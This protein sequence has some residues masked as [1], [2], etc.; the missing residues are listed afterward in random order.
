MRVRDEPLSI[1]DRRPYARIGYEDGP[2]VTV[3]IPGLD[4]APG[5]RTRYNAALLHLRASLVEAQAYM[6]APLPREDWP[7]EPADLIKRA[8]ELVDSWTAE[9]ATEAAD[10]LAEAQT[11]VAVAMG[12]LLMRVWADPVHELET[13]TAWEA[14]R[15]A[16]EVYRSPSHADPSQA[17]GL[18]SYDE[19]IEAGWSPSEIRAICA[20]VAN[21]LTT[22][23][24]ADSGKEVERKAQVFPGTG[25]RS[26]RSTSG[27]GTGSTSA[28]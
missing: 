11:G 9:G 20:E 25:G 14:C 28:A 17:L 5:L 26:P 22:W 12:Y 23:M 1:P 27:G 15:A 6:L 3:R 8:E 21:L 10:I 18:D 2:A 7:D 19:L 4:E 24:D 13:R 16:R